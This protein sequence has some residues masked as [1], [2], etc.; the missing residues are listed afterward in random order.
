[1]ALRMLKHVQLHQDLY[2]E[3]REG[4]VLGLVSVIIAFVGVVVDVEALDG[5]DGVAVDPDH[6]P[7]PVPGGLEGLL[8]VDQ[9]QYELL[10][11][12]YLTDCF[13]GLV[14]VIYLFK[15]KLNYKNMAIFSLPNSVTVHRLM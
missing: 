15:I 3:P 5:V 11:L 7:Q 9:V 10:T 1:M 6:A 12:L 14:N 4:P 13:F 8:Y 2:R